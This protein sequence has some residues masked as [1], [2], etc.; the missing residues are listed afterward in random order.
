MNQTSYLPFPE[1]TSFGTVLGYAQAL[2]QAGLVL[3]ERLAASVALSASGPLLLD[4]SKKHDKR[5][6]QLDR[7]RRERLNEVVLQ[8]ISG[9]ER[10]D[11]L[12]N[13]DAV[14][15][16]DLRILIDLEESSARFYTDAAAVAENVLGGLPRTFLKM[17]EEN[18][19]LARKLREAALRP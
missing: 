1:M 13:L 11:Y 18:R 15:P 10:A 7:V 19:E 2:E 3:G 12:P 9:M 4:C 5:G 6:K 8:P 17:A 14:D 16:T